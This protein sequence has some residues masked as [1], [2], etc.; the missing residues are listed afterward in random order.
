MLRLQGLR[1]YLYTPGVST[2]LHP[3]SRRSLRFDYYAPSD[4]LEGLGDFVVAA[5]SLL[6]TPL[7][8]PVRLSHVQHM[9]LKRDELGGAFSYYPMATLCG[10]PA[11]AQGRSRFTCAVRDITLDV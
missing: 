4:Y 6:S 7:N 2:F 8:I 9:R 3:A 1:G 10:F 11:C 5:T